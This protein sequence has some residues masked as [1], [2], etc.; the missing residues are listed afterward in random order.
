MLGM[1]SNLS[2]K[3]QMQSKPTLGYLKHRLI[4]AVLPFSPLW[5]QTRE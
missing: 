2:K 5:A 3:V 1:A 4:A